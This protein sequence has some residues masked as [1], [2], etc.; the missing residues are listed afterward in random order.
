MSDVPIARPAGSAGS[1][2]AAGSPGSSATTAATAARAAAHAA[3]PADT[4]A[5]PPGPLAEFWGSFSANHGAVLGLVVVL[6]V[7]A[8]A[9][10]AP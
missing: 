5:A 1:A 7:L 2:A 9:A 6:A 8:M 3:D 10:F 4:A